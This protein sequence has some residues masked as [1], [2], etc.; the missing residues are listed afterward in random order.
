MQI[1]G[2]DNFL[3]PQKWEALSDSGVEL[4]N[5]FGPL[6]IPKRKLDLKFGVEAEFSNPPAFVPTPSNRNWK[7]GLNLGVETLHS[8]A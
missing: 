5:S 8:N 3:S 6:V 1:W 4:M 7:L 2:A